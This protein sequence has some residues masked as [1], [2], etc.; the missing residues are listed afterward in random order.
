MTYSVQWPT[1]AG[2]L[3]A[4][5]VLTCPL[6]GRQTNLGGSMEGGQMAGF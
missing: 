3:V 5:F 2:A 6:L 1:F 4:P